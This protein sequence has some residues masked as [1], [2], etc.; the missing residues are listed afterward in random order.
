VSRLD[1]RPSRDELLRRVT[2]LEVELGHLQAALDGRPRVEHAIGMVMMLIS[3]SEAVAVAA[4]KHVSQVTNRKT[5]EVADLITASTSVGQAV[6]ADI[7]AALAD[8]MPPK[9]PRSAPR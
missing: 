6:P 7:A 4:L 9:P 3:C 2:D 1:A 5:R 8:V